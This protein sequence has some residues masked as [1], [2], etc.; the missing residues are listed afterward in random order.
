M[1][2]HSVEIV[3]VTLLNVIYYLSAFPTFG[4][5]SQLSPLA[6]H[7][8]VAHLFPFAGAGPAIG[9]DAVQAAVN[10][11]ISGLI[12]GTNV[13]F[14]QPLTSP[15]DGLGESIASVAQAQA[16]NVALMRLTQQLGGIMGSICP[17]PTL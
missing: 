14:A 5:L 1:K 13:F 2:Y 16:A 11:A 15:F 9:N 17:L 3:L 4:S 12:P 6:G 10:T 7:F 8:N